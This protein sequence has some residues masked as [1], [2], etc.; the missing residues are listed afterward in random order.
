MTVIVVR[1]FAGFLMLAAMALPGGGH[2]ETLLSA[3][4]T[5]PVHATGTISGG[6]IG[7]A[8]NGSMSISSTGAQTSA[9]VSLVETSPFDPVIGTSL[10][11]VDSTTSNTGAISVNGTISDVRGLDRNAGTNKSLSV[12]AV[13]AGSTF[14][15]QSVR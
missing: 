5:G 2:A 3:T 13:G 15:A 1:R 10:S 4:N 9:S 7:Y 14:K 6:S 12:S 11:G 8:P